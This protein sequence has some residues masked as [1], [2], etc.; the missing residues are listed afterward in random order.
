MD[1]KTYIKFTAASNY[2]FSILEQSCY[3]PEKNTVSLQ[4]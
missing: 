1:S 3:L 4:K 2:D